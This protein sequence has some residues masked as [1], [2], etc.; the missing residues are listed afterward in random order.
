MVEINLF[1][2]I[3]NKFHEYFKVVSN[4]EYLNQS[5]EINIRKNKEARERLARVR[6]DFVEKSYTLKSKITHRQ[7]IEKSLKL[8]KIIKSLK[9]LPFIIK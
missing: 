4:F 1:S 3:H 2:Q 6:V 7:N 5:L 8:L 9:K